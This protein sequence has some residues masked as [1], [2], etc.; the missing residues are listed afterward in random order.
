[1]R[2]GGG[3]G[4]GGLKEVK[5]PYPLLEEAGASA[6]SDGGLASSLDWMVPGLSRKGR[7]LLSCRSLIHGRVGDV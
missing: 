4:G 6:Y 5:G 3:G 2:G 7:L 1:M